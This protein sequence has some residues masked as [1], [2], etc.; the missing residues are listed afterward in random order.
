MTKF[1]HKKKIIARGS[2]KIACPQR[3]TTSTTK[4]KYSNKKRPPKLVNFGD[5][6]ILKIFYLS[7]FE[8]GRVV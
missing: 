3:K 1:Y 2:A 8:Y 5:R 6:I 7:S 4:T